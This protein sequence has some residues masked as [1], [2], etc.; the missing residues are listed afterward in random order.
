[1][2]VNVFGKVLEKGVRK[3]VRKGLPQESAAD[4]ANSCA[5]V[6]EMFVKGLRTD[7]RLH[8]YF[9]FIFQMNE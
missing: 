9:I 6:K 2:F 7:G 1:M 8:V 3:G 5:L 4:A